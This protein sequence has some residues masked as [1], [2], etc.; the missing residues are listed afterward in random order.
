MA[1]VAWDT[2]NPLAVLNPLDKRLLDLGHALRFD[3]LNIV[4]F[5]L[6]LALFGSPLGA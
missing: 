6:R 5:R 2:G 3:V 4:I 1:S